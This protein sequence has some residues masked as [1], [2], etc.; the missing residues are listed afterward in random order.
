MEIQQDLYSHM[1]SLQER[2][3]VYVASAQSLGW[4]VK[5]FEEWLE[6]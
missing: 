5:T 6:S 2:Y 3:N 4:E 1:E